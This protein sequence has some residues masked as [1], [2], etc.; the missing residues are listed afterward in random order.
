MAQVREYL[1]LLQM[2]GGVDDSSVAALV[3]TSEM[4]QGALK[5]A[6]DAGFKDDDKDVSKLAATLGDSETDSNSLHASSMPRMLLL[7]W[8][9]WR[10]R[11]F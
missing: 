4:L 9:I 1:N 2:A 10:V 11:V 5:Q 7:S 3:E 8:R 6:K